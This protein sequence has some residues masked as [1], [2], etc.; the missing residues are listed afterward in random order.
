MS[1]A[2]GIKINKIFVLIKDWRPLAR[3]SIDLI[4]V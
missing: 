4:F 2:Y 1:M 3:G